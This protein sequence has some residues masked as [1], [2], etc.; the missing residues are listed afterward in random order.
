MGRPTPPFSSTTHCNRAAAHPTCSST[1]RSARSSIPTAMAYRSIRS[2]PTSTS[3][4]NS[5]RSMSSMGMMPAFRRSFM[6]PTLRM[7]ASR[8]GPSP[9][10]SRVRPSPATSGTTSTEMASGMMARTPLAAG[11]SIFPTATGTGTTRSSSMAA[12]LRPMPMASMSS[13]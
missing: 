10:R 3:T 12:P 6:V 1:C 4:R 11:S 5:G 2:R 8:N 13:P 9:R 7:T